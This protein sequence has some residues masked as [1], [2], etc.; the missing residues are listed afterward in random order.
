ML[1][2]SLIYDWA[3][4]NNLAARPFVDNPGVAL[5]RDRHDRDRRGPRTP[6][7]SR[8]PAHAG[9]RHQRRG[10]GANQLRIGTGRHGDGRRRHSLACVDLPGARALSHLAGRRSEQ[11]DRA[12]RRVHGE[13]ACLD[14]DPRESPAALLAALPVDHRPTPADERDAEGRYRRPG[15]TSARRTAVPAHP[16]SGDPIR[17]SQE[18]ERHRAM[19]RR[20]DRCRCLH[21]GRFALVFIVQH[22]KA[23]ESTGGPNHRYE[24]DRPSRISAVP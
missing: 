1:T 5:P 24:G 9:C 6:R 8:A 3:E 2:S 21:E 20:V 23:R 4:A 18:Y 17:R 7:A 13:S 16:I 14:T 11:V 19:T 15:S 22:A 12:A 10:V